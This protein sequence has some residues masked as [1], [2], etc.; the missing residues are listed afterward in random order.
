MT[1]TSVNKRAGRSRRSLMLWVFVLYAIF[2]AS[3][4]V[5]K[6]RLMYFPSFVK[7]S[8]H[9]LDLPAADSLTWSPPMANASALGLSQPP[10]IIL[11]VELHGYCG[12]L[13]DRVGI[14]RRFA[15]DVRVSGDQSSGAGLQGR[16]RTQDD[17]RRRGGLPRRASDELFG[18]SH[19]HRRRVDRDGDRCRRCGSTSGCSGPNVTGMVR[20]RLATLPPPPGTAQS[21]FSTR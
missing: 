16:L 11:F 5:F 10:A 21:S 8:V 6:R 14:L 20:D 17:P 7:A 3:L 13:A 1:L 9:A 2:R 12:T 15:S 4:Y 18:R 19:R